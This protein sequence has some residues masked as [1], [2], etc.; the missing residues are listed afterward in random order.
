MEAK[1]ASATRVGPG[2]RLVMKGANKEARARIAVAR[3]EN[4]VMLTEAR[5]SKQRLAELSGMSG[6]RVSLMTSGRKPVSDPFAA[7]IE[8]GIGLPNGWLDEPRTRAD[9]PAGVRARLNVE[10]EQRADARRPAGA[11][12]KNVQSRERAAQAGA[13]AGAAVTAR[14]APAF[15]SAVV[16]P[17]FEKPP[18]QV[19]PIAEALAKT[20]LSLSE[21]DRLSEDRA[22][23]LLG[24]LVAESEAGR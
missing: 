18:G 9:V 13:P 22:F 17:L 4:L 14:A 3:R 19:G 7:A 6:S 1:A 16:A 15:G 2:A 5:G 24:L 11:A 10:A 21:A 12:P 23:H 8:E 20:V